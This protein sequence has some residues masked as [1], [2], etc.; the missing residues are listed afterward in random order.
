[1]E[2]KII[3]LELS[4]KI[5][6]YDRSRQLINHAGEDI[7]AL[8]DALSSSTNSNDETGHVS[9]IPPI[10]FLAEFPIKNQSK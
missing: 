2:R 9:N 10:H 3:N 8:Y 4:S 6:K 7:E 1:M 5:H